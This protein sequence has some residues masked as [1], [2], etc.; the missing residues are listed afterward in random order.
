MTRLVVDKKVSSLLDRI[1]KKV[2][3]EVFDI[4]DSFLRRIELSIRSKAFS[5]SRNTV[6]TVSEQLLAYKQP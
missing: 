4:G 3:D 6:P 2:I 1:E 5:K